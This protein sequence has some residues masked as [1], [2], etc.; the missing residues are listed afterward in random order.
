[1]L[2]ALSRS[3]AGRGRA[4]VFSSRSCVLEFGSE[5][6]GYTDERCEKR[7]EREDLGELVG[8]EWRGKSGERMGGRGDAR[9]TFQPVSVFPQRSCRM[10]EQQ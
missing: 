7:E 10:G 6:G 2:A 1:M 9:E 8:E 3:F 4:L 5:C